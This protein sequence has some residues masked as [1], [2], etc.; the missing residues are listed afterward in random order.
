VAL[1]DIGLPAMDGYELAPRLREL[2]VDS[3]RVPALRL[4]AVTGYGLETDRARSKQA[5]F[6]EHLVKP[7]D[8]GRLALSIEGLS[9]KT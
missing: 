2:L 5:G 9:A 3:G 4:L 1:L 7:I 6:D 8:L